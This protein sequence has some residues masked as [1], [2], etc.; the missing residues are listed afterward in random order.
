M[1]VQRLNGTGSFPWEP[2]SIKRGAET[3]I[4]HLPWK[5]PLGTWILGQFYPR[6]NWILPRINWDWKRKE[7]FPSIGRYDECQAHCKNFLKCHS[8]LL[9]STTINKKNLCIYLF[10]YLTSLLFSLYCG[11]LPSAHAISITAGST[12]C[13][14]RSFLLGKEECQHCAIWCN[15]P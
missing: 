15:S 12:D 1:M 14:I 13:I 10:T 3:A 8:A 11:P 6:C 9:P 2:H 7:V 4:D 5:I